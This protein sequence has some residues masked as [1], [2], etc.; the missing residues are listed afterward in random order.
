MQISGD[1]PA[2]LLAVYSSSRPQRWDLEEKPSLLR[3]ESNSFRFPKFEELPLATAKHGQT[4]SNHDQRRFF[5]HQNIWTRWQ[6]KLSTSNTLRD[7]VSK[8]KILEP[9]LSVISLRGSRFVL[10]LANS[11]SSTCFSTWANCVA[12]RWLDTSRRTSS[13]LSRTSWTALALPATHQ[14][15]RLLGLSPLQN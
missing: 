12:A 14:P 8:Y 2:P 4:R 5:G 10:C 9:T 3:R 11:A 1:D 13:W 7:P 6:P 15:H